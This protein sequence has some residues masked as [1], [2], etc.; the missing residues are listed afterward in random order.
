MPK[1]KKKV[2][3]DRLR[4]YKRDRATGKFLNIPEGDSLVYLAPPAR[5]DWDLPFLETAVHYGLGGTIMC[6]NPDKNPLLQDEEFL[7]LCKKLKIDVSGP[8]PVCQVLQGKPGQPGLWDTDKDA[9]RKIKVSPRFLLAAAIMYTRKDSTDAWS[10]RESFDLKPFS[11]GKK[12]WEAIVD[13]FLDQD[14]DL[15]DPLEAVLVMIHREGTGISSQYN[16]KI[17]P[18]SSKKPLRMS[19][20]AR[21]DLRDMLASGAECDPYTL[22]LDWVKPADGMS[23]LL[24]GL[25]VDE[26]EEEDEEEPPRG[27]GRSTRRTR[28]E[29]DEDE[30]E[31]DEDEPEDD[32]AGE[33]P[34]CFGLDY[35]A[36]DED[37][38]ECGH[39]G[40]CAKK[41]G[42]E[43]PEDDEAEEEPED[44]GEEEDDEDLADLEAALDEKAGKKKG[45]GK[46]KKK[47]AKGKGGKGRT[48]RRPS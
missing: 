11:I 9:A 36:D 8:C 30:D 10:A 5:D 18:K 40:P 35:E 21:A 44:D 19:K 38:Q 12:V 42:A 20:A 47:G 39:K 29:E 37:C 48:R 26:D 23:A 34:S 17:D 25:D 7:R 2:D 33:R 31:E 13:Q 46:P 4:Q 32:D 45:K 43:E 16:V 24:D 15:T 1:T 6:L 14:A 3:L 22:A 28:R 41:S 27:R